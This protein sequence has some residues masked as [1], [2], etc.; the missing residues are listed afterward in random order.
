MKRLLSTLGIAAVFCVTSVIAQQATSPSTNQS[1]ASASS[2]QTSPSSS[3]SGAQTSM[4]STAQDQSNPQ[5]GS[6]NSA[7]PGRVDGST[8]STVQQQLD[9]QMPAGAQVTASVADDG[10]LKLTGTVGSEADK[11][12]AEQIAKQLSIKNVDNRIQ[13]KANNFDQTSVPK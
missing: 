9:R 1:H 5:G 3:P 10:S 4:P 12:K 13:V 11:A 6:P 2:A 7:I 8:P